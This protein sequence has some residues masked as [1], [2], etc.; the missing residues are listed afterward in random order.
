MRPLRCSAVVQCGGFP[1]VTQVAQK[2]AAKLE[3]LKILRLPEN[4]SN[5]NIETTGKEKN[6]IIYTASWSSDTSSF[7]L[8]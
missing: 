2:Y 5:V 6:C 7:L 1:Q 8:F 3:F 4:T